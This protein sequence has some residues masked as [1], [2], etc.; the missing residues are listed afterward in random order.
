MGMGLN[1]SIKDELE[2]FGAVVDN[3]TIMV[4]MAR[5]A[6]NH[7]SHQILD[8]MDNHQEIVEEEFVRATERI[9]ALLANTTGKEQVRLLRLHSIL[10]HL[11]MVTEA[12]REMVGPLQKQ[13]RGGIPFSPKAS[14][15]TNQLFKIQLELLE[16]LADIFKT[17]NDVLKTYLKNEKGPK[18]SQMCI[19]FATE[20]EDRLIEGLCTPHAAPIFLGIIDSIRIMTRHE[21]SVAGLL[22]GEEIPPAVAG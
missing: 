21:M 17:D 11:Q 8:E 10:S 4:E 6:F 15:E 22:L 7:Q 3:L 9:D 16:N 18:L 20:H 19:D 2:L 1:Q 12:L 14:T 5:S 13:I